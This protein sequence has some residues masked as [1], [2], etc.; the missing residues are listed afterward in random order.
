MVK[1]ECVRRPADVLLNFFNCITGL[2]VKPYDK[3]IRLIEKGLE[4]SNQN[5]KDLE[6]YMSWYS[7][8]KNDQALK[9]DLEE[10]MQNYCDYVKLASEGVQDIKEPKNENKKEP[11][12]DKDTYD[13]DMKHSA[14]EHQDNSPSKKIREKAETGRNVN[15]KESATKEKNGKKSTSKS[16]S[17]EDGVD[18][19]QENYTSS[20]KKATPSNT[21]DKDKGKE[22]TDDT[23]RENK[24]ESPRAMVLFDASFMNM[25]QGAVADA[26]EEQYDSILDS[27]KKDL[28]DFY[29]ENLSDN[30]QVIKVEFDNPDLAPIENEPVHEKLQ[31]ILNFVIAKEPVYLVGP[32]GCGKNH[33]CK[34][35][36][37]ILGLK[38][39]YSNSITQEYKLTGFTDANGI[40]H[41]TQFYKAFK[42]GGLFL[43]DELD[44]S[45]PDAL[46]I[47]NAAI[48]NGY[49]DFPAPAGFVEAHPDF[50][51]IA[52]GN[53]W[54][55]GADL[56]Y[57][58]RNQLDMASLDRFAIV[59]LNYS[60]QIEATLCPN[61]EMREFLRQYREIVYHSGL[62][63]VVSY[64][65]FK[66]MYIMESRFDNLSELLDCCLCKGLCKDDLIMIHKRL[67]YE[68]KYKDA[69][70]ELASR[71]DK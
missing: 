65:V 1:A 31:E 71:R 15:C 19:K 48:S 63:A 18:N 33:I 21:P 9:P 16:Q 38:F 46:I 27:L 70:G 13:D 53:T 34:Q 4:L 30:T 22:E 64:R 66:R 11:E 67:F 12:K 6:D 10:C 60:P 24:A 56:Q 20:K 52:A 37:K 29:N 39:Y 45:L 8:Y 44:A 7:M 26:V 23:Q 62:L 68:G 57:V 36:A 35:I 47:L 42:D 58:G 3:N 50:R 55:N 32:A 49:F 61:D 5:E 40:Y 25:I 59:T 69:L 41:E 51:V 28:S 43:L 54:G 2:K 17:A 14:A